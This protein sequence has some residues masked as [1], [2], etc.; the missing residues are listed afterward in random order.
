MAPSFT[1][2]AAPEASS[3]EL[4]PCSTTLNTISI[5]R[6]VA[7]NPMFSLLTRAP[8]KMTILGRAE[9]QNPKSEAQKR[10]ARRQD[11]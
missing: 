3:K 7:E 4:A 6:V 10:S 9:L 5:T 1:E 2:Q 8:D 11:G